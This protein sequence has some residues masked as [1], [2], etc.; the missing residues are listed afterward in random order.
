M[1]KV[2]KTQRLDPEPGFKTA[3]DEFKHWLKTFENYLDA[4]SAADLEPD[5]YKV[6]MN[7]MSSQVYR[8]FADVEDYDSAIGTL[9]ELYVKPK[10][11]IAAR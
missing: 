10:N 7:L 8:Y 11:M 4:L 9:K 3:A 2:L 6:L 5:K 1:Q